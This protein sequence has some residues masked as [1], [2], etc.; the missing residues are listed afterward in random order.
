MNF[1][2]YKVRYHYVTFVGVSLLFYCMVMYVDGELY[3]LMQILLLVNQ[4]ES[5]IFVVT[6][7]EILAVYK[8][9]GQ[10]LY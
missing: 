10:F 9:P 1:Y 8:S 4:I 3:L 5:G 6:T 7:L 2:K